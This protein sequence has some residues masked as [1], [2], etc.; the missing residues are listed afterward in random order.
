MS[1]EYLN[2]LK[3]LQKEINGICEIRDKSRFLF[4]D[5]HPGFPKIEALT[6]VQETEELDPFTLAEIRLNCTLW[7]GIFGEN[8]R[9]FLK[10]VCEK[11]DSSVER[12]PEVES[13][14]SSIRKLL[15][16]GICRA[17]KNSKS[18]PERQ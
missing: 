14:A 9:K 8:L 5:N 7:K 3:T 11:V 10:E 16:E 15:T 4:E 18:E 17:K 12:T 13:L 1:L 2:L 6:Y